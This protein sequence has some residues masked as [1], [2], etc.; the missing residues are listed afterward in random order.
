MQND[1]AL[2]RAAGCIVYHRGDSGNLRILLIYDK[3][4]R[5]TL[6]KGHLEQ[7]ESEQDAAV[8]EVLEETGVSGELGPLIDRIT[9]VVRT[10][11]GEQRHKQVAFFLM[12]A[13]TSEATPQ[14]AEGISAASW[15]A[16]ADALA[17]ID[18]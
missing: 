11:R 4:G 9:Y 13:V 7:G 1:V 14:V 8:R 18:Y 6:P 3:Y 2:K 5:W 16:P 15:F 12:R 17:R 10:K